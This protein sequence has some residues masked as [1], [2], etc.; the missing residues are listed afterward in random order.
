MRFNT[1][2]SI[3]NL[4]ALG[5]SKPL[6]TSSVGSEGIGSGANSA[7][8]VAENAQEFS[9]AVIKILTDENYAKQLA[10]AAGQ[11]AYDWNKTVIQQLVVALK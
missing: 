7:Y 11:Y 6:V 2:L 8:L 1:G 9:S 10:S 5:Y 4:E 3:K